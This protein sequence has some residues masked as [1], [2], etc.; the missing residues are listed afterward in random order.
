MKCL[1]IHVYTLYEYEYVRSKYV[2]EAKLEAISI[3]VR[4][5]LVEDQ[6]RVRIRRLVLVSSRYRI[7]DPENKSLPYTEWSLL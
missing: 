6:V 2:S 1:F 4:M 3:L 7:L 5:I